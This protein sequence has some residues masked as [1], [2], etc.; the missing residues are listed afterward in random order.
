[1]TSIIPPKSHY[2]QPVEWL[3]EPEQ[4]ADLCI[5]IAKVRRAYDLGMR[6]DMLLSQAKGYTVAHELIA[7]GDGGRH[8][9][10]L[11]AT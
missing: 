10:D 9:H 5:V 11:T 6:R 8:R 3:L 7:M 4:R 1:M 2:Q